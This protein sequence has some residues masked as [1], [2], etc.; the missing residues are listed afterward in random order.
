MHESTL[1]MLICPVTRSKLRREG[2]YLVS[3]L[4]GLRYPIRDGLPVLLPDAA[5]VPPPYKT[6]AE[7]RAGVGR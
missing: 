2:D 7:F 5:E 6:L 3:Q 4:G 1:D